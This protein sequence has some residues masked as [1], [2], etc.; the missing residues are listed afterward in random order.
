MS[1]RIDELMEKEELTD[2]EKQELDGLIKQDIQRDKVNHIPSFDD[3]IKLNNE[4]KDLVIRRRT[5]ELEKQKRKEL[6]KIKSLEDQ[7]DGQEFCKVCE[8]LVNPKTH[9]DELIYCDD[10]K[11]L[12]PHS[13]F[14]EN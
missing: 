10:C 14:E 2:K 8:K 9:Y 5:L 11:E 3:F 4:V 1:E 12:K 13:H 6:E 7:R